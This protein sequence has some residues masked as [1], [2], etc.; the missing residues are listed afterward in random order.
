MRTPSTSSL[1]LAEI[2]TQEHDLAPLLGDGVGFCDV[3][4]SKCGESWFW[5]RLSKGE[6]GERFFRM[7]QTEA[8]RAQE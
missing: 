6:G 2:V 7:L 5:A 3:P 4:D 1:Q 8:G